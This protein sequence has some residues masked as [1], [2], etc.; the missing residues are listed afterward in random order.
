MF[1]KQRAYDACSRP[2]QTDRQKHADKA[3]DADDRRQQAH[4]L[5]GERTKVRHLGVGEL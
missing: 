1:V 2:G 4:E 5:F 3:T